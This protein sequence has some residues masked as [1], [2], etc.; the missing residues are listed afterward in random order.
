ML[1]AQRCSRESL[2]YF[3]V[4]VEFARRPVMDLLV[5]LG[6]NE[7][8][9]NPVLSEVQSLPWVV[10]LGVPPPPTVTL[11]WRGYRPVTF[12]KTYRLR[13]TRDRRITH[14]TCKYEFGRN[15]PRSHS[16]RVFFCLV[17]LKA[18]AGVNH[19][20][21]TWFGFTPK[22]RWRGPLPLI[23]ENVNKHLE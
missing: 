18:V 2:P 11:V 3:S 16:R 7:T 8:F 15:P 17:F 6:K 19:L 1:A 5:K 20:G 22:P 4:L 14:T 21:A 23:R 13:S 9:H 10:K 12:M